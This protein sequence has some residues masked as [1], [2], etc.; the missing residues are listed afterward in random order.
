M[1]NPEQR[2]TVLLWEEGLGSCKSDEDST[3]RI[4]YFRTIDLRYL[5]DHIHSMARRR[6]GAQSTL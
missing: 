4:R 2:T 5:P 3:R 1:T 6:A